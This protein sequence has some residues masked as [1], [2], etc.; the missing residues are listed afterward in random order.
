MR[1]FFLV[2]RN[3]R[4]E[5]EGQFWYN[6][7][8]S[9]QQLRYMSV[10]FRQELTGTRWAKL[11]L[12]ANLTEFKRRLALGCLPPDNTVKRAAPPAQPAPPP[13]AA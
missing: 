11:G 6:D 4:G 5:P 3:Q 1:V 8:P 13:T 9:P 10:I 12:K 7:L 2:C